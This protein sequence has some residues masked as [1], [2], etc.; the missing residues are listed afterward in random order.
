MSTNNL[1]DKSAHP[2]RARE[3]AR[4]RA[5]IADDKDCVVAR[6]CGCGEVWVG[7]VVNKFCS[8][9]IPELERPAV[10]EETGET[11]RDSSNEGL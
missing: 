4:K 10:G 11:V 9:S 8:T 6:G 3:D 5:T 7:K 1:N 2:N